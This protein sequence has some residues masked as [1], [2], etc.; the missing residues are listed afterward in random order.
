M[1]IIETFSCTAKT[2]SETAKLGFS[3][4]QSIYVRPLVILLEGELGAGKTTFVQGFA[5]GL[6]IKEMPT[7]PT[8]AL[9]QRYGNDVL[10]HIDLYRLNRKQADEFVLT[11]DQFPGIRVIEW[12]ERTDIADWDIRIRIQESGSTDPRL[13]IESSSR[14]PIE[15]SSRPHIES[16]NH[17]TQVS[18]PAPEIKPAPENRPAPESRKIIIDCRDIPIPSDEETT[19]WLKEALI[20][21]HIIRHMEKVAEA[22]ALT[23]A[24]LQSQCRFVR[25]AAVRAAALT[26]DLLRFVDF[27]TLSGDDQYQPTPEETKRWTTL[28]KEYGEPH[29]IAAEKFIIAKGYPEI[30]RIVRPHRG[31]SEKPEDNP[32]TI[33]QIVL[34]YSD[35]RA[36]FDKFATIDERFDDFVQRYSKGTLTDYAKKWRVQMKEFERMLFPDGVTF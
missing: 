36:M 19:A 8:Y 12:P 34:A 13:P 1:S 15:S 6:G 14:L 16:F 23:C 9:E 17:A 26:H 24:S 28:K 35:K 22:A 33:E 4:A 21:D 5:K 18:R 7:S 30:A 25:K 31:Y 3:L 2:A 29:E 27:K 11:L 10:S 20:S 32:S